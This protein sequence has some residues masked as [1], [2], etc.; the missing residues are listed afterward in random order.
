MANASTHTDEC[1]PECAGYAI[2]TGKPVTE[3]AKEIGAHLKTLRHRVKRHR[4]ELAGKVPARCEGTDAKALHERIREPGQGGGFL[5]KAS[6]L[7]A[8]NRAK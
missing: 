5:E 7:F 2:S 6:A 1:R 4:D 8:E 3:A